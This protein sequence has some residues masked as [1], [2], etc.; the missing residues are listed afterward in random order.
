MGQMNTHAGRSCGR[1]RLSMA[2]GLGAMYGAMLLT[3]SGCYSKVTG[4]SGPAAGQYR[5]EQS[6]RTDTWIDR[7]VFGEETPTKTRNRE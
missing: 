5:V 7:Q 6:D 1:A 3:A 4:A 2:L